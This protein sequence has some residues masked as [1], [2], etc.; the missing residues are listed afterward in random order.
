MVGF[1][2]PAA[3]TMTNT[4]QASRQFQV[5]TKDG[6]EI[7]YTLRGLTDPEVKA[8]A[9]FCASVFSYKANPPPADYF[10]RHYLND[11]EREAS[12]IRVAFCGD[13][14]V[15]SCR[16]F[17]RQVSLGSG[18]YADAGGIGEVCTDKLHRKRGLSKQ[19]L[20]DAKQIISESG[21]E[22]SFLHSAPDFF[23]V[24]EK[25]GY[26]CTVTQWSVALIDRPI[27]FESLKETSNCSVRLARFPD[28]TKTLM[29][30]HQEFSEHRFAGCIRRSESYWENYIGKELEGSLY[31]YEQGNEITGWLSAHHRG[32]NKIRISEF[33]CVDSKRQGYSVL[34]ALLCRALKDTATTTEPTFE[35]LTPSFVME[36]IQTSFDS[37]SDLRESYIDWSETIMDSDRGWMYKPI[38]GHGLSMPDLNRTVPHWIWPVDSF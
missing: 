35:L 28:D 2:S 5:K 14:M 33:G 19:L 25:A 3:L 11:P 12:F 31:V 30:V 34:G 37:Q 24:Y 7:M 29:K 1:S 15:G 16:V 26:K 8:W 38:S 9:A 36:D 32:K 18:E 23:P 6:S 27:L 22:L 20:Q 17:R 4:A 10:E 13:Q 21:M